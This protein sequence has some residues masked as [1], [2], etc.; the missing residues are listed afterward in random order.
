MNEKPLPNVFQYNPLLRFIQEHEGELLFTSDSGIPLVRFNL[1]D[2]GTVMT[3]KKGVTMLRASGSTAPKGSWRLPFV[4][5]KGRADHTL[6]FYAANI[7]PEHIHAALNAPRFLK[8]ITGKF[9]MRKGFD[10]KH[11]AFLELH[12]ELQSN[13]RPSKKMTATL[14]THVTRE[15]RRINMEYDFL[16]NHLVK[17]LTPRVI[18]RPYQDPSHFRPGLKPKY[19]IKD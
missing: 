18:L 6:V 13:V 7:Y 5:L 11:E 9:A 12:V 8:D 17:D 3:Y 10:R 2:A 19:F 16:W 1:H 4:T 14:T 15:L